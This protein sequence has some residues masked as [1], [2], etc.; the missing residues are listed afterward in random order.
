MLEKRFKIRSVRCH[1]NSDIKVGIFLE[2][3]SKIIGLSEDF[4]SIGNITDSSHKLLISGRGSPSASNFS[5]ETGSDHQAN[6]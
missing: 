1:K 4:N 2:P 3:Q 5:I 6:T